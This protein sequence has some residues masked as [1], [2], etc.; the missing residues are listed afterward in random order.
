MGC[1]VHPVVQV[2]KN[3]VWVNGDVPERLHDR[4]YG[5]FAFLT[6]G[7]VRNYSE[8]PEVLPKPRGYPEGWP[9]ER[10]H[11]DDWGYHSASWLMLAELLAVNYDTVFMDVRSQPEEAGTLG[12]FLGDSW[13]DILNE[14]AIQGNPEDV[15][16]VFH[17]DS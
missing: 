4:T 3:G 9:E 13:R 7:V 6:G 16:I 1:D 10:E 15:R 17:F 14:L 2:R 8:V 5:R 12:E 11:V